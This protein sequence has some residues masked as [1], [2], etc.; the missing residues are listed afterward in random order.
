MLKRAALIALSLCLAVLLSAQTQVV[1][2][3]DTPP[4]GWIPQGGA[5][6]STLNFFIGPY[7]V[8]MGDTTSSALV[9]AQPILLSPGGTTLVFWLFRPHQAEGKISVQYQVGSAWLDLW[10]PSIDQAYGLWGKYA[11]PAAPVAGFYP[12]RLKLISANRNFAFYFDH[13]AYTPQPPYPCE[14]LSYTVSENSNKK[15]LLVW[16]TQNENSMAGFNIWRGIT[17]DLAKAMLLEAFIPAT[18]TPQQQTYSYNDNSMWESGTYY[19]WV[20]SRDYRDFN[21]IFG[22]V[23]ILIDLDG[24]EPPPVIPVPGISSVFPNPFN[25]DAN[26]QYYLEEAGN[27]AL[28]VMNLRGQRVAGLYAGY[29]EAGHYTVNWDGRDNRGSYASSGI[30]IIRL[31][32]GGAQYTRK[33]MLLK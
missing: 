29:R 12:V 20:E 26:I 27:A 22:P 4:Y 8:Y 5:T 11:V 18:N 6:V 17:S 28:D 21:D 2:S 15:A 31:R 9:S 19:Y 30:Y 13:I 25:A 7:S 3:F 24:D 23:S 16:V 10:Q 14:L 32:V 33:A 1:E